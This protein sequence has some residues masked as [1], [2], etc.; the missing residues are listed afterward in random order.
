MV[1]Q[2]ISDSQPVVDYLAKVLTTYLEAGRVL[3][4]VPGGSSIAIAAAVSQKLKPELTSHLTVSLTDERFGIVG[5]PDSNWKQLH[6]A[7]F[8]PAHATMLPVLSGKDMTETVT[9]FGASLEEILGNVDY[10]LGFF[11]IGADGH[12]AGILPGSPAVAAEQFA[13]GYDAGNFMR[14]TMTPKAIS[15]LDEAVAYAV[16]EEKREALLNLDLEKL[17]LETQPAQILKQVAKYTIFNDQ[18][19]SEV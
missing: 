18:I 15:Y 1:F 2:K 13:A 16:G 17:P 10:R 19:E 4:L 11:G 6:D 5:H 7:G 3:W 14:I 12:T 9:N 8:Q